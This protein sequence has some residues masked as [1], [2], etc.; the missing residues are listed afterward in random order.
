ML[1]SLL[2][3]VA[4]LQKDLKPRP[5]VVSDLG[6]Y[7]WRSVGPANMGGRVADIALAPQNSKTFFV[8]FGT[9]GLWK[10]V[11]RGTTFTPVFDAESTSSIGS[12]VVADAPENWKGWGPNDDKKSG[13]AKVVWVGTGEGNGRNSSSWGN[14]VYRS[15]DGGTSWK[16]LG[17]EDSKDIPSLAVDP[18]DPDVCYA[19]CLG[20]LWGPNK[21]RGVYKTTDGGKSWHPQ[22]QID[23]NTGACWVQIDPKNPNTI[24]AA[25]YSRR[26]TAWRFTSGGKEG[27]IYRSTD[28]GAHWT[29]LTK[30][31][32]TQTGRIG[33]DIYAKDPKTIF[34]LVESD[35]GGGRGIDAANSRQGGLF[36][37]D[38]G[39]DSWSRIN[40]MVPRAFYFCKVKVDPEDVKRVYM[41]GF[42]T[43]VSD[44]AGKSFRSGITDKM[45]GDWHA[46][47]IDPQD[48]EHLLAGSDGGMY[49]SWDRGATWDFMNSIAVG[50]F[51]NIALDNSKPYRIAGGLQDNESW[52]GPSSINFETGETPAG[53]TGIT[54]MDWKAIPGGDGFHVAFDPTD[55][56]VIYA[57]SQGGSIGRYHVDLGVTKNIQPEV[58]EGQPRIRFNWNSPFLV[59]AHDPKSLYIGGNYVFKLTERGD[60]FQQISPDLTT[61]D[62]AKMETTG[63]NAETH[64]TVVAL[65]ESER[66]KGVLWSGSDDGLIHVTTDDGK[67]WKNV[68][69]KSV[70]GWYIAGIEASHNNNETAY[71]AVDGHRSDHYDPLILMTTNLGGTWNDITGDLPKGASV[72]VVREDRFVPTTLYCGTETGIYVSFDRGR[73]WLKLGSGLPTVG[74]H[75]IK[76][77][78]RDLDLVIA[79]HGRS[80]YVLDD[81]SAFT[82]LTP[83]IAAKPIA[84][85]RPRTAKPRARGALDGLWGDK[86]FHSPNAPLTA[87]IHYWLRER[88][89]GSV[90]IKIEDAKGETMATLSGSDKAGINHVSWDM[91]LPANKRL[92]N[93]GDEASW[94]P[95]G[96]YKVTLTVGDRS[97]ST[98]IEILAHHY[99]DDLTIPPIAVKS[100]VNAR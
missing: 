24:Y 76:Q 40:A 37:S 41:L 20:H 85:F 87:S 4:V 80:I 100:T 3:S 86:F 25:M 30:G 47:T 34:A 96:K 14:G 17:L 13:K 72:R 8:A 74:V 29:K 88:A 7:S 42:N 57:E 60:N 43:F 64:C 32:P 94:V 45:H 39:G 53:N 22:L 36:R 33:L 66:Q 75:D 15:V 44:D 71:V 68:T 50:E 90:S 35:L 56:N 95:G 51:Y 48:S 91:L 49:Q 54:N 46:L 67:E 65:A 70:R 89:E 83:E 19:A 9:G 97:E 98:E 79:T 5:I 77:H 93:R 73:H 26:R 27:G 55:S 2:A 81:A 99:D 84:I 63:S 69:P 23:E 21:M 11:N 82:Q 52:Y 61:H 10:T 58:K 31:L 28:K 16:G 18:R 92:P 78:P 12:V 6:S 38:D 1:A 62:P 59:S